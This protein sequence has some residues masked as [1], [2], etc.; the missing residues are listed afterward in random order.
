M[1][2][3]ME[4]S[5]GK[6]KV[7]AVICLLTVQAFSHILFAQNIVGT[8]HGKLTVPNGSLT[9]IFHISQAG[10]GSYVTTLDSPD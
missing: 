8:W 9:I 1:S 3:R 5:R 7:T 2:K 6:I 4:Y 10:N